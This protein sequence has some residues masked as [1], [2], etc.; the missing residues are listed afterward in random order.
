MHH[1][2]LTTHLIVLHT[3]AC[4]FGLSENA[5]TITLYEGFD[6]ELSHK[7]VHFSRCL[8]CTNKKFVISDK[9]RALVKA[10][11]SGKSK[12]TLCGPKGVG[13]SMALAAIATL[14]HK[15]VPTFLWSPTM[16]LN[17][18]FREYYNSIFKEFGKYSLK[19][20]FTYE[21]AMLILFYC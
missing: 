11:K 14:C 12:A 10:L 17:Q 6:E 18:G 1:C 21:L 13:K 9:F 3:F 8:H 7:R 19:Y 16:K 2:T 15:K 20:Y 4:R 5:T